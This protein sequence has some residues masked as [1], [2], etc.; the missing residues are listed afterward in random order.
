MGEQ[1]KKH[2]FELLS[3][4]DLKINFIFEIPPKTEVHT[5]PKKQPFILFKN[6]STVEGT[7]GSLAELDLLAI[8]TLILYFST[9]RA[10]I[11]KWHR[12]VQ[13]PWSLVFVE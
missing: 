7:P 10:L 12:G 13:T 9:L 2:I 6:D 11:S 3:V 5:L 1:L 8:C 4:Q